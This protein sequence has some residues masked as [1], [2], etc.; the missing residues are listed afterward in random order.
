MKKVRIK[1][2]HGE[3]K[4]AVASHTQKSA[5]SQRS[6]SAKFIGNTMTKVKS[7]MSLF[8]QETKS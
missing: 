5:I 4:M 8:S 6:M 7:S 3:F 2:Y 1:K